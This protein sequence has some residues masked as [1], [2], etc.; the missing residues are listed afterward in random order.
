M[1]LV[2]FY[3]QKL[4]ILYVDSWNAISIVLFQVLLNLEELKIRNHGGLQEVFKLEGLLTKE[5]E[6]QNV[7]LPSL[8]KMLLHNLLDLSCIWKGP[9][10]LINLNN[11]EHLEVIGCKKLIHLF[12]PTPA[13]SVQNLKFLKIERC[14]EL[15]HLIVEDD[16][17]QIISKA[18]LQPLCFPKLERVKVNECN[19]LKF[20]FPITVI[21]SLLELQGLQINGASQLMEVFAHEDEGDIIIQR[22]VMLPKLEY[23]I[24]ER[25]PSLVNLCPRNHHIILPPYLRGF[26]LEV[27]S[28]PSMTTSFTRTLDES[29]HINGEV[30]TIM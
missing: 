16:E 30:P 21:N 24:L 1:T 18:H 14:D 22:D 19:K 4:R 12:T 25:L 10:Q 28:C 11:L 27:K 20:L 5:G 2:Y 7:L 15:E 9:T 8:K 26:K 3:L 6:Q 29:V 23:I 13:R 17:E